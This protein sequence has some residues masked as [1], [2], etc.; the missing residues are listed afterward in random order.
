MLEEHQFND[1][2][3]DG[4]QLVLFAMDTTYEG[5]DSGT[6]WLNFSWRRSACP[7]PPVAF[8]GVREAVHRGEGVVAVGMYKARRDVVAG[9]IFGREG[10][11]RSSC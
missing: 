7:G 4:R 5:D 11:I 2:P 1:P 9:E 6:A 10:L 8:E 3:V